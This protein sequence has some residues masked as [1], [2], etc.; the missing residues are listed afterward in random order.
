VLFARAFAERRNNGTPY[1]RNESDEQFVSL[2]LRR[3][4]SASFRWSFEAYGQDQG[5]SSTFSGVNATRSAETP[6]SDQFAVPAVALGVAWSGSWQHRGAARTS[7]GA[8]VRRVR[9]ETREHFTF[10]NGDFTRRRV[11][12]GRQDFA[13]AFALH[14][15][16]LSPRLRATVGARLDWWRDSDGHRDEHDRATGAVLRSERYARDDGL[17]F[18]PSAGLVWQP[19]ESWR[20]RLAAQH[21]FRRPTLNELYRPFRVGNVIT[22]ANAGLGTERVVAGELG[23]EWTRP[24]R[25]RTATL[26]A[27]VFWNELSDAVGNVTLVSGPGTFP[28]WGFIPV[29]GTGRQRLNLDRAR[30]RGLE[31]A[32]AWRPHPALTVRADYLYNDATVRRAAVTPA[33]AGKRLAQVPRHAAVVSADWRGGGFRV[34]P[35]I[36]WLDRQF[37]DDENQ[38]RLGAAVVIDLGVSRA[39]GK[40]AEIFLQTENLT[41]ARVETG[42]S[43]MGVV[44]TGTPRMVSGGIRADW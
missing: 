41:D 21:A 18:S 7:A 9:G 1:Q 2:S 40:H 13:G 32:A 44:N 33:L 6:A 20:V 34:A 37:E 28:P 4:P 31:L 25:D 23:V 12:G 29:G 39:L 5:F 36:R 43:A 24:D 3:Q 30:V 19:D 22:E 10:A 17:E 11:A 35:R 38:L 27:T 42:R 14:E 8:D 26:G 16:P 15:R